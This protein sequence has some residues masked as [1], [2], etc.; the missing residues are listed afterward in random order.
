MPVSWTTEEQLTFLK[1][2]LPGFCAAQ[3]QQ[4]IP[5]FF[6]GLVEHWFERTAD[7]PAMALTLDDDKKVTVAITKWV[8][9]LR[10]W[11][12]WNAGK[13]KHVS[14]KPDTT[15]LKDVLGKSKGHTLQAVELYQQHYKDKIEEHIKAEF[16]LCGAE[17]NK[18]QMAI[19]HQVVS[20]MWKVEDETIITE[21]MGEAEGEKQK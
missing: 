9:Q 5:Q 11:M 14:A 19:H 17:T 7:A 12:H 10:T 18:E 6:S 1:E 16:N 20:E 8:K 13:E 3:C 21:I 2:E 15:W 4:R